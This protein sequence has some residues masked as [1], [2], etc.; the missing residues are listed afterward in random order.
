MPMPP[1]WLAVPRKYFSTSDF[2]RPT[3]SNSCAPQYDMYVD[4][5]IFDMIFD[6]PLPTALT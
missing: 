2:S 3:A 5:P 6:R 1:T 4:T